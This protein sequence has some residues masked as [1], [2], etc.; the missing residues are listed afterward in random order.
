MTLVFEIPQ[1]HLNVSSKF[2]LLCC[3]ACTA[4]LIHIWLPVGCELDI[5]VDLSSEEPM[6][7]T[8]VKFTPV[9]GFYC[10]EETPSPR[11]LF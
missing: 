9:L 1:N 7:L 3:A 4:V 8:F 2:P 10:Y 11:Q 6:R 5:A